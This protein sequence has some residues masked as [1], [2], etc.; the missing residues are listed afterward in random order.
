M[1]YVALAQVLLLLSL[2]NGSPVIAK[3]IFGAN[4]A[5]PVDGNTRFIDGRPLVGPSKTIRGIVV[6]LVVTSMHL[7][8]HPVT[9]KCGDRSTERSGD[10][11][12]PCAQ[13][14]LECCTQ[15]S[16]RDE[17]QRLCL[18]P[19]RCSF[20]IERAL[21]GGVEPE[22]RKRLRTFAFST[23]LYREVPERLRI[24]N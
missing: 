23:F 21:S 19:I 11:R 15:Q 6:S 2:A 14:S 8:T 1:H 12:W 7:A 9:S 3:R 17:D 20:G 5:A 18:F 16:R 13:D 24:L 22:P 4:Y 10:A